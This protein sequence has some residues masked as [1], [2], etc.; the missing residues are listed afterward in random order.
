MGKLTISIHIVNLP[1]YN[2]KALGICVCVYVCV[3]DMMYDMIC[4]ML[5]DMWYV[6]WYDLMIWYNTTNNSLTLHAF[7]IYLHWNV[8]WG[9]QHSNV[10]WGRGHWCY[11]N[12]SE[13]FI[14]DLGALQLFD[15]SIYPMRRANAKRASLSTGFALELAIR[16][17]NFFNVG[18]C[19]RFMGAIF[20]GGIKI[21][22]GW[23]CSTLAL[24]LTYFWC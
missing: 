23:R 15:S 3:C 17:S 16:S 2:Q 12:L 8:G 22:K 24:Q 1:D 7:T 21:F 6:I 4:D 13:G 11:R 9:S 20:F 18:C 19:Y 5:Y 14:G 10:G